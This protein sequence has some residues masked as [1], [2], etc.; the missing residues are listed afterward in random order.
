M[1]DNILSGLIELG[2]EMDMAIARTAND[3]G[4]EVKEQIQDIQADDGFWTNRTFQALESIDNEA[5]EREGG[6]VIAIKVGFLDGLP[7]EQR[8]DGLR[9]YGQYIANYSRGGNE[10]NGFL[11]R[12]MSLLSA[13]FARSMPDVANTLQR[14]QFNT[15]TRKWTVR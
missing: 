11:G 14:S 5:E 15:T 10:M 1:T 13:E 3:I 6:N 9:E 12:A 7:A 4:K 8:K 2:K